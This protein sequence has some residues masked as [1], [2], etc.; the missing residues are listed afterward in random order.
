MK[1]KYRFFFS[2][3]KLAKMQRMG[4]GMGREE[5]VCFVVKVNVK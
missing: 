4:L 5:K 2:P 1:I 3:T